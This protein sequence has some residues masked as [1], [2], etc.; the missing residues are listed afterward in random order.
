MTVVKTRA[1]PL[2]AMAIASLSLFLASYI[3]LPPG[4]GLTYRA[5]FLI[6]ENQRVTETLRHSYPG[7][8]SQEDASGRVLTLSYMVAS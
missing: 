7:L 5:T 4:T 2:L 1:S 8:M 6:S 3:L